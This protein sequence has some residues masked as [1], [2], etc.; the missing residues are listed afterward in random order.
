MRPSNSASLQP[1]YTSPDNL[2]HI[3]TTGY[4]AIVESYAVTPKLHEVRMLSIAGQP[5][6]IKALRASL[7]S[8]LS[9]HITGLGQILWPSHAD[10]FFTFTQ[11]RLPSGATAAIWLPQQGTSVG[12]QHDTNAYILQRHATA[13]APPPNFI[14]IID[15]VLSCPILKEWAA[16]LW[17]AAQQHKWVLPLHTY[18]CSAWE[19]TPQ[20]DAIIQWIQRYL[21][22]AATTSMQPHMPRHNL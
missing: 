2:I 11:K 16:P 10:T 15:R 7:S 19:F 4:N 6:A 22:T 3:F 8:G 14:A 17:N 9:V 20:T 1:K 5:D 13:D 21:Q 18:N 12:I